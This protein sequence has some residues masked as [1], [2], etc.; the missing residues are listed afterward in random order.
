MPETTS[1][2]SIATP[3]GPATLVLDTNVVL[4]WLVFRNPA[5]AGLALALAE[6]R[7]RWIATEAMRDEL[8]H[9]LGRGAL[10]PWKPDLAHVTGA[11][12]SRAVMVAT[13]ILGPADTLR[14]TDTD[15]QKFIDLALHAHANA[16]L[17][18]DRAVLRLAKR[19]RQR[20]VE[21]TTALAWTQQH[22][23]L[24]PLPA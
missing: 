10:D 3:A 20:G 5:C 16:L 17:S 23:D 18:S 13:P 14:C 8:M 22:P 2:A 9:V 15:D 24:T 4:D 1:I 21:F 11:W 12:S 7:V 19:A 6:R